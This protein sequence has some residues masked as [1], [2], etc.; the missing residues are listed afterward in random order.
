VLQ[1]IVETLLFYHPAVWWLSNRIRQEREHCCDDVAAEACGDRVFY[2]SSLAELDELRGGPLALAMAA[3]GMGLLPRIRRI[4]RA[5]SKEALFDAWTSGTLAGTLAVAVAIILLARSSAIDRHKQSTASTPVL[6][7][8]SARVAS[9]APRQP[10]LARGKTAAALPMRRTVTL[11]R[12]NGADEFVSD[13]DPPPGAPAANVRT[14]GITRDGPESW[15]R[16]DVTPGAGSDFADLRQ[17]SDHRGGAV[18]GLAQNGHP[19]ADVRQPAPNVR[20]GFP[21]PAGPM[22]GVPGIPGPLGMGGGYGMPYGGWNNFGLLPWYGSPP[23]QSPPA[24]KAPPPSPPAPPP[25]PPPPVARAT[26]SVGSLPPREWPQ[27][28]VKGPGPVRPVAKDR[29]VARAADRGAVVMAQE[30]PAAPDFVPPTLRPHTISP[31]SGVIVQPAD[32]PGARAV[33]IVVREQAEIREQ[34]LARPPSALSREA[35]FQ[36]APR[37]TDPSR[38]RSQR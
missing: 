15:A 21:N 30:E 3:N 6:T 36:T 25:A 10:V 16:N 31:A 37:A 38:G 19:R 8:D 24:K 23:D 22:F 20:G 32:E 35:A 11:P 13:F 33:R 34:D 2:A 29:D 4:L 14:A 5:P 28:P 7:V 26:G 1:S 27:K 12:Q 9:A 17:A 18:G